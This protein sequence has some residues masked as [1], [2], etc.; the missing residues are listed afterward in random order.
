MQQCMSSLDAEAL[1]NFVAG[2]T[3]GMGAGGT[4]TGEQGGM[5]QSASQIMDMMSQMLCGYV[6]A[7]GF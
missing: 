7:S 4:G 5:E 2:L 6:N 3:G 1:Q